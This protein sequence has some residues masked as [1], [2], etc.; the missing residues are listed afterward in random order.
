[1]GRQA[2][3]L[4]RSLSE[5]DHPVNTFLREGMDEGRQ[6]TATE[7]S[8]EPLLQDVQGDLD[9]LVRRHFTRP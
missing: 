5:G 3:D 4:T 1:M 6:S 7:A 2:T 9:L 8:P